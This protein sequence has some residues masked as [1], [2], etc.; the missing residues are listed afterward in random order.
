MRWL[1]TARDAQLP[2]FDS[3][4]DWRIW[5]IR[6]G[7][8]WGKT[9][10]ASEFIN[11]CVRYGGYKRPHIVGA[12]AGDVRD[13]MIEGPSGLLSTAP[14]DFRP[15]YN[16]SKREVLWPNGVRAKTFTSEAPYRLRGPECDLFWGDEI[17]YWMYPEQTWTNLTLGWRIGE[18]RIGVVTTTPRPISIVRSIQGRSD[19]HI[20][21][22]TTEENRDNLSEDYYDE[23]VELYGGTRL[24]RQELE[25]LLLEDNP[26]ALWR[27]EWIDRD[28]V[29]AVPTL[30]RLVVSIDPGATEGGNEW[31]IFAVGSA[32]SKDYYIV[33]D[34]STAASPYKACLEAV[35]LLKELEADE[36]VYEGNQGG[37]IVRDLIRTID[38]S[39]PIRKVHATIGKKPRAAPVAALQEQGRL[40]M[41]GSFP[42][43]EDELCYWSDQLGEPSPNR[44]DAMVWGVTYL[45]KRT[46]TKRKLGV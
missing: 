14:R 46:T 11:M 21:T 29:H 43:L 22:G 31:G 30:Q 19:V 27:R 44:L 3:E 34:R 16:P 17:A 37:D 10:A 28:R 6:T 39:I 45:R 20:T 2:P 42:K 36:I 38:P 15:E 33:A 35:K 9:R 1:W 25:G 4:K 18:N 13:I 32:E 40:H 23:V 8:G 7:R 41:V 26:E 24:G 12:T 5:F